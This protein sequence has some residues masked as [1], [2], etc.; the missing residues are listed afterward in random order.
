MRPQVDTPLPTVE[1]TPATLGSAPAP[2]AGRALSD[3]TVEPGRGLRQAGAVGGRLENRPC[4]LNYSRS[5]TPASPTRLRCRPHKQGPAPADAQAERSLMGQAAIGEVQDAVGEG[6]GLG[7][8]RHQHH[9]RPVICDLAEQPEH[10]VPRFLVRGSVG[11][12]ARIR[13]GSLASAGRPPAAAAPHPDAP[14]NRVAAGPSPRGIDH[15]AQPRLGAAHS[16]RQAGREQHRSRHGHSGSRWKNWN[17]KPTAAHVDQ[18]HARCSG[19]MCTPSARISTASTVRSHQQHRQRSRLPPNPSS[20]SAGTHSPP[21]TDRTR[22]SAPPLDRFGDA[23]A[24]MTA[25]HC[26]RDHGHLRHATPLGRYRARIG[27]PLTIDTP[28]RPTHSTPAVHSPQ[29]SEQSSA[30]SPIPR[31]VLGIDHAH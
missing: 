3:H 10:S 21:P 26:T 28:V 11:S 4:R 8:V 27:R 22:P 30:T 24:A 20:R 5:R 12:S 17:T 7:V 1:E 6:R 9:H 15:P 19:P 14:G 25:R 29:G 23:R 31:T 16:P 18:L 13:R 2:L